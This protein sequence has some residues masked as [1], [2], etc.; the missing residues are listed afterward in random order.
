MG[1]PDRTRRGSG[2]RGLDQLRGRLRAVAI[3]IAKMRDEGCLRPCCKGAH[4]ALALLDRIALRL[5]GRR[6]GEGADALIAVGEHPADG[7]REAPWIIGDGE[8]VAFAP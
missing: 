7:V 1:V 4:I 8:A 6:H 5:A 3:D 2:A